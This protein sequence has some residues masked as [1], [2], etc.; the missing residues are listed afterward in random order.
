MTFYFYDLETSG[1]NPKTARI[2]QFAGRRTDT[3]LKPV[4]EPDNFLIKLTDDILPDPGAILVHGITP[5]VTRADGLNEAEF[6][7]Y[8]AEKVA[9]PNTIFIG[10]NNIRFDDDFM[11]FSLW[12]NFHDAYEWQW[13]EGRGRWDLLDVARMT[14]ALRPEGLKWP[15][16]T[17]GIPINQL[18]KLA[19]IN[20]LDHASVHDALSDVTA[21]LGIASL[22]KAKQPK[23]FE[24][25]F[26]LRDKQKVIAFIGK[27]EP[28][29]Y[30]SGRYPSGY[31]KTTIAV[32]VAPHPGKPGALMYDLRVAPDE[33]IRLKPAAL[34]EL[35]QLRGKEAP[36]F[37]VK[38]LSYNRCPAVAPISVLDGESAA[39]LKINS[40]QIDENFKKLLAAEDFGDKLTAA[41]EIM[42]P[43]QQ[44]DL[45]VDELTA[46]N[47]LYDGFVNDADR[48]KMRAV[49]QA[50]GQKLAGLH[51]DFVDERLN[52]LLLLYKARNFPKSL[53]RVEQ[54]SWEKYRIQKLLSGG[55]SSPAVLYFKRIDELSAQT[56]PDRRQ[57]YLLEELKL[58]GQ[59]ILP[60]GEAA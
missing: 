15:V 60:G 42:Y 38:V 48:A 44:P 24:Y 17:E 43:K 59:S 31:D 4:G 9:T 39:R 1:F 10:Y 13:K 54:D 40:R 20:K 21:A 7:S 49:R 46:D 52:K 28:V 19:A 26:N 34:A 45:V 12:R 35:W 22:L 57:K 41:V 51:P 30:T 47:Q 23:L 25:L 37:P 58:W 5:Q 32:M 36:Y 27:G 33:F 53:D 11:R 14:R 56:G 3:E 18:A 8:F 50:D 16:D 55:E 29:V 6:L 2:M